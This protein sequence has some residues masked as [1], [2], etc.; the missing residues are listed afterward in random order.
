MKVRFVAT[1]ALRSAGFAPGQYTDFWGYL[2]K[3][4]GSVLFAGEHTSTHSQ[5]YLNGGVESG[6]RA[7]HQVLSRLGM[8]GAA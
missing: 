3:P 2:H 5:G 1:R 6:E 7:A 8:R 4:A